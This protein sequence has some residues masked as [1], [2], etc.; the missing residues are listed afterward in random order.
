M[1]S[2]PAY[3]TSFKQRN[4]KHLRQMM[5]ILWMSLSNTLK[6]SFSVR[7]SNHLSLSWCS[8]HDLRSKVTVVSVTSLTKW[9]L[10]TCLRALCILSEQN[11]YILVLLRHQIKEKIEILILIVTAMLPSSS[12]MTWM[13][14]MLGKSRTLKLKSLGP[15]W[16]WISLWTGLIL[17]MNEM[18]KK[19][20]SI[21][22]LWT[23]PLMQMNKTIKKIHFSLVHPIQLYQMNLTMSVHLLKL[24]SS[25]YF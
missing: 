18:Q 6:S 19:F 20:H 8:W 23:I 13:Q 16:R 21:M 7:Q 15:V 3:E 17:A 4:T 24:F 11:H 12:L 25:I 1:T 22:S 2:Q 9:T 10:Q 5:S 14:M